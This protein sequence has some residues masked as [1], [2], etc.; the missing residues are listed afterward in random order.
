[1]PRS[2]SLTSRSLVQG[3]PIDNLVL[4]RLT[5]EWA[6]TLVGTRLEALRQESGERF[7]LSFAS[8]G[9]NRSL[10]ACLDPRRP[11]LAEV[12]RRWEGPLW[13]PHPALTAAAHA[14]VGRLLERI[15]KHAPDR[16]IR[17]DF[18]GGRGI[19][20][21]L[22]PQ[23][24]NF[25][26]LREG[27]LVQTVFRHYK[28]AGERMT[29][30]HPWSA[31]AAPP[32]KLDPFPMTSQELDAV[33]SADAALDGTEAEWL[34]K[35]FL[36]IGAVGAELVAVASRL[37][38]DSLGSVLRDRLDSILTGSAEIV[39]ETPDG[40]SDASRWRLLPWRPDLEGGGMRW[41]TRERAAATAGFYFETRA[42]ADRV[43]DR[44]A[45]LGGILRR[46][47]SR[48]RKAE[49]RVRDELRGFE[50]PDKFQ[51]MGEA[52]LAGLSSARRHRETAIVADPYDPKGGELV[53]PA[54]AER[55]LPQIAD[56]L[57]RRQRRA[58]RGLAAAGER[59]D[60][61]AR[62]ASRLQALLDAH[63][64]T[65]DE[66]GAE[67][68]EASM[69]GDGLAVGLIAPTRAAR[70]AARIAPPHLEGVRMITSKDG[71]TIL[72]GRTGPDNDKLT[73]KIAAPDDLWLHAAGV[74]GAH[75]VI[76]NPDRQPSAPS[77]TLAEAAS[78]ALW[79]SDA[80]SEPGA[81]VQWTRRK[82]VRRAK[83]GSSGKVVLKRF[84]TIRAR[85]HPPAD[86][87]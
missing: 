64:R 32:G 62:R 19:I 47:I 42:T 33:R 72:V 43:R 54:P 73:F 80:R 30:G 69:R 82:N 26:L 25:A 84:E 4:T 50:D 87:N 52:L 22:T 85:A 41:V 61:L 65:T 45:A 21:E 5:V 58:R 39:V 56:D 53:I 37:T 17:F 78:L 27:G 34:P 24:P 13:S 57:F 68:L 3:A 18:G 6:S 7:R 38:G 14:L 83:G 1:M 86:G 71:W 59:G 75:V 2:A 10:I 48:T 12:N 9:F 31:R 77:A 67:T 55:S 74:P 8:E 35:R 76:R 63:G 20:F 29:L 66:L 40:G 60:A 49:Q 44:I 15:D 81:D 11:W 51:R 23:T 79:F 36:G 70:A 46:E 28:G 16:S